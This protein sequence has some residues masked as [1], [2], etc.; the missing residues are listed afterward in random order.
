MNE[1][2]YFFLIFLATIIGTRILIFFHRQ[3]SP[4][5][6][7]LRLHH[8]MYGIALMI[9]AY[10]IKNVAIYAFGLGLLADQ[11]PYILMER[12]LLGEKRFNG[13]VYWNKT[14]LIILVAIIILI[15]F[16]KD[17]LIFFKE[18]T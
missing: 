3:P 6:M 14:H 2:M 1:A 16:L 17:Y 18:I 12:E 13:S 15:F 10:F 7:G 9:I 5:V 4:T 8:Y 11:I